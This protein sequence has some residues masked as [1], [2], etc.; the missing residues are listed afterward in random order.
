M[1]DIVGAAPS[2]RAAEESYAAEAEPEPGEGLIAVGIGRLRNRCLLLGFAGYYP[3]ALLI[4]WLLSRS[5]GE[6]IDLS[7]WGRHL[8]VEQLRDKVLDVAILTLLIM[9]AVFAVELIAVGWL[10]SSL[11]SLLC[12]HSPSGRTDVTCFA[13]W[14]GHL[15]NIPR[16][17]LTFGGALITGTWL[18]NWLRNRAGISLSLDGLPLVVQYASYFLLFT[19]WD[20]WQH[21]LEHSRFFWPIHRYHHGADEFHILTSLRVHPAAFSRVIAMTLPLALVDAPVDV[22]AAMALGATILR[23]IIHSR[24]DSDFGWIGRWVL[25]SPVDHRLHHRLDPSMPTGNLSLFPVWDHLF[26]TWQAGGSQAIVIGVSKPYRQGAWIL[27]DMWRDYREFLVQLAALLGW[28]KAP[29]GE[30]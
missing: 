22:I 13:L 6:R 2:S 28:R 25:Q 18:H 21:R 4:C 27:P 24:I 16:I 11:R 7:I 29:G 23:F 9:P 5:L 15:L 19:F 30:P 20:Y 3:F 8:V 12:S 14:H 1:R 17:G 26:G 10:R